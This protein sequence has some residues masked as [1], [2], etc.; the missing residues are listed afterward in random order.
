MRKSLRTRTLIRR[1]VGRPV[2][3]GRVPGRVPLLLER[4]QAL[5]DSVS[6]PPLPAPVLLVHTGGK[7]LAYQA[8]GRGEAHQSIPGFITFLPRAARAEVSLRGV[9]EGTV[10]YLADEQR[11]PGWFSHVRHREPVTFT[12]DVVVSL[13][14][15]LM[16]DIETGG[17]SARYR[18]LLGNALLA[19]LQRELEQSSADFTMPATRSELRVSHT[20]IEYMRR[21]LDEHVTVA[22]LA[23]QCGLGA[24]RFA[25]SFR[26]STGLT[27]HRYLRKLRLER[28]CELLRS[29]AL[30]IGEVAEAVG[31]R[32]QSHFCTAFAAERGLTPGAYRRAVRASTARRDRA[33]R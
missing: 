6:V 3:S 13:V 26:Q 11:V 8:F 31:F 17:A 10:V 19:E 23:E 5:F 18:R 4:Y 29:T 15:R 33:P 28:A 25:G 1:I 2:A 20:A 22:V 16:R 14:R 27:P 12:N 32:G 9:G 24:T 21:H 30:T 7:P